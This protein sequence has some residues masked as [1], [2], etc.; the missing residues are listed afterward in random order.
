MKITAIHHTS[1]HANGDT[2][3]NGLT[4]GEPIIPEVVPMLM[5]AP[6]GLSSNTIF[7]GLSNVALNV[8]RSGWPAGATIPGGFNFPGIAI[9]DAQGHPVPFTI[10][11][12]EIST[13]DDFEVT[14]ASGSLSLSLNQP[15]NPIPAYKSLIPP[16]SLA[17]PSPG[18]GIVLEADDNST[19]DSI[20]LPK[21]LLTNKTRVSNKVGTYA[22]KE[23]GIP[24]YIPGFI[25]K[26]S[27]GGM[28]IPNG[29]LI[30]KRFNIGL[31]Q[32][33]PMDQKLYNAWTA[34][35]GLGYLGI[36]GIHGG[37][38]TACTVEFEVPG[39]IA[40]SV[41]RFEDDLFIGFGFDTQ[42]VYTT[43]LA[44]PLQTLSSTRERDPFTP[45]L[46]QTM[47]IPLSALP[48][49]ALN[50]SITYVNSYNPINAMPTSLT[51]GDVLHSVELAGR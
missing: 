34:S 43:N 25:N 31:Q 14:T 24:G 30:A 16:S 29:Q 28:F 22:I 37:A 3:Y 19:T 49:S 51:P 11:K 38:F 36:N 35:L 6:T 20:V 7:P 42:Q 12:A 27:F 44:A 9:C 33:M 5:S 23:G 21:L 32:Q 10:T 41:Q 15:G 4:G 48:G 17:L 46:T 1:L 40:A 8:L 47:L 2:V 50:S 26:R 39:F 18:I 45:F 13:S